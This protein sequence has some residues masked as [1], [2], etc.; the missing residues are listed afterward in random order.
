MAEKN[1]KYAEDIS[2]LLKFLGGTDNILSATHCVSRLRLVLKDL[3]LVDD[4]KI[5]DLKSTQATFKL[6]NNQY[7]VIIGVDVPAYFK[8]FERQSKIKKSS[9]DELKKVA[10]GQGSWFQRMIQHF[11]EIF[12]PIIPVVV[13]SGIILGVRNIFEADFGG[14]QIISIP[15]FKGLNEFLLA[16]ALAGLWYLPVFICWSIFKKMGG[17]PVFGI[18]IGLSL[19][20]TPLLNV[21]TT[22]DQGIKFIWEFD[23]KKFGFDFGAWQ[24][25]WKIAYTAQ[26]IP[27]IGVA[28]LGVYLERGLMKI[29]TPVLR[30]IFVPLGTLLGAYIAGMV[31]IGP[32][33]WILGTSISVAVSYLLTN[34]IVKY[35]AGPIFGLLYAPLVIT[36][37]H[38]SL[39]AVMIQ[40]AGTIG[41]SVIFPILAVS[42]ISQGAAALMFVLL[43]RRAEKLKQVGYSAT[44]SAWLGVTEP[45]MYGVNLRYLSPF[46]AA[47]IGAATGS[48]LITISGVTAAGIGNGAWLG[49]L[50]I[51]AN[52]GISGV[53]TF[54]GTGYTWFILSAILTTGVTMLM[55]WLL[56]KLPKFKKLHKNVGIA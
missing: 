29:V 56:G 17:T 52:S 21:F 42:N 11:S 27:A 23:L 46:L 33:G 38:H 5:K 36:G 32:L 26:V 54:P 13:A 41:G 44:T 7:H 47:M 4:A 51:Q 37:L 20:I 45:A 25:P 35:I 55:T 24:F 3:T 49:V 16:P 18:L 12:I 8:E 40:N 34:D 10:S 2:S 48:L 9:K 14:F 31:V 39:N 6:A 43:N 30:Q 19:L 15:F 22:N 28:F 50:S 1:K 53:T